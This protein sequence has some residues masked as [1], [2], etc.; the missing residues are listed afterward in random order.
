MNVI[1][2]KVIDKFIRKHPDAKSSIESWYHEAKNVKWKNSID[3]KS[4][5]SSASFLSDNR[6]VFNIKGNGYRLLTKVDYKR[7]IVLIKKLVTHS[8]YSKN[9]FS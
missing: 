5:Y 9:S 7:G 8:E 6:V 2:R 1:S 4:R 3:I